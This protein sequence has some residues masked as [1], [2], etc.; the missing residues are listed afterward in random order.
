MQR[1]HFLLA[2]LGAA[3]ALYLLSRTERGAAAASSAIEEVLVTA[4]RIG[5]ALM[6]RGLRNNNPGNI[7]F[8]AKNPWRGQVGNDGGYGV[9]ATMGEG[10]RAL[11]KQ[12]EAYA[13]RGLVTVRSIISTWAPASENNTAAY[14]A[15]VA[16]AM[17]VDADDVLDVTS[18]LPRLAVAIIKHEN[19]V[20]PLSF[21]DIR[22]WVHSP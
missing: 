12:L 11:G 5:D 6:P 9:Y 13:S 19:G 14:V 1:V 7:R 15:A 3:I 16:R 18:Y 22:K 8:I 21:D 20:Q 10:V 4:E 2:G 17:N